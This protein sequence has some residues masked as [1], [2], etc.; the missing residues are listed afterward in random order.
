MAHVTGL[1]HEVPGDFPLQGEVVLP[2][3]SGT[4]GS[5]IEQGWGI[6]DISYRLALRRIV[7][8]GP[9]A[10]VGDAGGQTVHQIGREILAE[11]QRGR[12][13]RAI[14]GATQD[15]GGV[16]D[17]TDAAFKPPPFTGRMGRFSSCRMV[18]LR[19]MP[20]VPFS[21]AWIRP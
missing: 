2:Q 11:A 3:P 1:H 13:P 18:T 9:P 16:V 15:V 19:V 5:W 12:I 8:I 17:N 14:D 21:A 20:T 7:D 10:R 6:G 4:S